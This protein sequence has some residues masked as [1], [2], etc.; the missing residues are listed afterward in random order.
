M[1]HLPPSQLLFT[2]SKLPV[3]PP[4]I[5]LAPATAATLASSQQQ[6]QHTQQQQQQQ[7]GQRVVVPISDLYSSGPVLFLVLRR[8][9]C[10]MCREWA[11]ILSS[12]KETIN[13]FGVRLVAVVKE[14]IGIEEFATHYWKEDIYIDTEH[15][16]YKFIG[17][18]EL[19]MCSTF[20]LM[21]SPQF[22]SNVRKASRN[23]YKG[24]FEGE[25]YILGGLVVVSHLGEVVY[26]YSEEKPGEHP[27]VEEVLD[28]CAAVATNAATAEPVFCRSAATKSAL[29][30]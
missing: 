29:G 19:H 26:K 7:Q 20:D 3:L 6:Q 22:W 17:D 4:G 16:L 11:S 27:A 13:S 28:A 15:G 24:N 5:L 8:P 25:G 1:A 21:V 10:L 18:G 14:D 23:G 12:Y 30:D 2:K 9:G